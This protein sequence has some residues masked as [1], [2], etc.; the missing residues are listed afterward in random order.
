MGTCFA[1]KLQAT[2]KKRATRTQ[3]KGFFRPHFLLFPEAIM[4]IIE[5]T[6]NPLRARRT[7]RLRSARQLSVE[8]LETR[9]LLAGDVDIFTR[10]G[11]LFV[12]GDRADNSVEIRV[13]SSGDVVA[14]GL[15]GTTI[16]G[17]EGPVVIL[18]G[19]VVPDDM[20]VRLGSGDDT[21]LI[22]G[23]EI[24]DDL[25]INGGD[26][27]DSIGLLRTTVG[28]D[29]AIYGLRGDL[30][31]SLD[32]ST[33]NDDLRVVGS[34]GDDLIVFDE[35]TVGDD[36]N[37]LT[38]SGDDTVIVRNSV[39]QDTVFLNTGRGDDFVAVVGSEI[40]DDVYAILGGGDDSLVIEDS[41][42]GDRV[43]A[44]GG[45]GSD[46]LALVG[47]V[48]LNPRRTPLL[49]SITVREVEGTEAVID[50][51]IAELVD[52]GARRPTLV[53]IASGNDDFSILVDLL[54]QAGLVDAV[55]GSDPLTVFAPTNDAFASFLDEFG[56]TVNEDGTLDVPLALLQ[57]VL[58]FHVAE[59][60]VDSGAV[61]GSESI[62]TLQGE[63]IGV[64]V[65]SEGVTLDGR[66][67]LVAV[68]IRARNGIVHVIDTVLTP[69]ALDDTEEAS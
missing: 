42:L 57:S 69:S 32:L 6:R 47:D 7:R 27:D 36:T 63:S 46:S 11:D 64:D 65:S 16:N 49:L 53:D 8:T 50:A 17:S 28:D 67:G 33:I 12:T 51:A 23:L 43:I 30:N 60:N 9:R 4:S 68:D 5:T 3:G 15:D 66:A 37:V 39:H 40:G 21:I 25:I 52:A 24:S 61:V 19:G 13:E 45:S 34:R 14:E 10:R 41:S 20:R 35:S 2:R 31:F 44:L 58:T 1:S 22:D 26:G 38:S 56:L 29:A 54:V 62:A 59:G 18:E 55:S 48:E